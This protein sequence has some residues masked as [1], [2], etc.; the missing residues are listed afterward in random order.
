MSGRWYSVFMNEHEQENQMNELITLTP[1][2]SF[3]IDGQELWDT[4]R[5]ANEY[6]IS[7][8]TVRTL[9]SREDFPK[10][11]AMSEGGGKMFFQTKAILHWAED[12]GAMAS[13]MKNKSKGVGRPT[14]TRRESTVR[15]IRNAI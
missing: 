7:K 12:T 3:Y 13:I 5:I 10:P 9:I 1:K 15:A 14:T 2:T 11:Y 8:A 6:A 4:N